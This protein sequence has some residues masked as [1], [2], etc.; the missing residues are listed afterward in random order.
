MH[1]IR[2][3]DLDRLPELREALTAWLA[4]ARKV[5]RL[6]KVCLFGSFARG[7]P[8]EGSDIDLVLIGPFE[9]KLPY[10]IAEV[11]M[12]TDLPIEPLCYTPQEWQTMVDEGNSLALEVLGSGIDLTDRAR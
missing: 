10:R 9:G 8:H 1:P 12:T 4:H 11:L 5:F 2:R 7:T 6:E 3:I